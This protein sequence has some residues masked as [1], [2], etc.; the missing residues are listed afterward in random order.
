MGWT[1]LKVALFA[2]TA[3]VILLAAGYLWEQSAEAADAERFPPP[4]RM[5]DVGGHR[6]QLNCNGTAGGPTVVFEQDAGAPSVW[7]DSIQT[8]LSTSARVC[9]YDR[10][11]FA[12]SEPAGRVR[13]LAE[14]GEELHT[15]LHRA[16]VP[17][18]YV[19]VG[20]MSGGLIVRQFTKR[21][22]DEVAGVILVDAPEEGIL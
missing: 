8:T 18:P 9:T 5:V 10:A 4:G 22:R 15:L 19:L 3:V 6:L 13:S 1:I 16:A 20:L 12:W 11:G 21:H 17:G 2:L 7:L 14:I